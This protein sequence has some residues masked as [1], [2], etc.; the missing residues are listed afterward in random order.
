MFG[1]ICLFEQ[2]SRYY[3]FM[4]KQFHTGLDYLEVL[5][6]QEEFFIYNVIGRND[7]EQLKLGDKLESD[8][9]IIRIEMY[10]R[11]FEQVPPGHT[12]RLTLKCK[13]PLNFTLKDRDMPL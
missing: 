4:P 11:E 5:P 12:C 6:K 2:P 7:E 3:K 9:E 10:G 1:P 8:A 13:R